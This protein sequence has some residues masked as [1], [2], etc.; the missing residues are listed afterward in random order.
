MPHTG[1]GKRFETPRA[2][3]AALRSP[4]RDPPSTFRS[5]PLATDAR[6]P[7][8]AR[9]LNPPAPN[10]PPARWRWLLPV[11]LLVLLVHFSPLGRSLDY[12][13]FDF[14]SRRPLIQPE[15]P[16]RSALV[17]I[18]DKTMDAL[19][20]TGERWPFRRGTFAA[21]LAA[22][23]R[24][25]AERILVDLTFL[26]HSDSAE[27]D[28]ILAVVAASSPRIVLAANGA[29]GPA[30]WDEE[31]RRENAAWFKKPRT[32]AVDYQVDPDGVPRRYHVRHSLAAAAFD[33]PAMGNG[34]LL[35]WHG[36]LA[37][38]QR[39]GV[40][41][42]PAGPFI[43]AGRGI[44]DRMV[45]AAPDLTPADLARAFHAEPTI[46][47]EAA[48]AVRGRVV[49]VGANA[50][51]TFDVKPLP[52]G[53][54]EPGVL[55]HWTA[56]SNLAGDGFIRPHPGGSFATSIL[57]LVTLLGG[58]HRSGGLRRPI[59]AAAGLVAL[60]VFGS[61]AGLSFG[62][63]FPPVTVVATVSLAL[64]GIIAE[65]FWAE[66]AR[67]REIQ[68]MFGAY[69][70]P[71]VVARLVND[72]QS[73][74][75][76]GEKRDATVFFSDLAGFTDLS[77][78]LRDQPERMVE[79]VNA[80][81]EETSE[82]LHRHGAYVDKYIGDAVMAVFGA[83]QELH[84][85][86]LDACRAALDAQKALEAINAR[87]AADVGVKLAVR[88]GLNTGEMIVGNLGSSRKKNYTVMG[89]AVNLGS[90]LEGANKHFGTGI[91]MGPETARRVADHLA[92]RPLARLRVKGK[93]EAVEVFTLHGEP[94]ALA[95]DERE[96]LEHYRLGY[97]AFMER[98]FA[99]AAASLARAESLR[100]GDQTTLDLRRQAEQFC[101]TPPTPDWEPV[102]TLESK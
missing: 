65:R 91:L 4:N 36:G 99:D 76:R 40:P 27:Q 14:A 51:G 37:D 60:V 73:I 10:S 20:A 54:L 97:Y 102:T 18:N 79:V 55:I 31:F 33:P 39:R 57:A 72:P 58:V 47:G 82:C 12:S 56:W 30:F 28:L 25:G 67:K 19:G 8:D 93:Q 46:T 63:F 17:M 34:G 9:R 32:G 16:G 94:A 66:Q 52:I 49:F 88:I 95:A 81:L 44:I 78:Q 7:S 68:T 71:S 101:R 13:F 41:V 15:L 70:D 2:T 61:Y 3:P 85:H 84:N 29:Q 21:L 77:E 26:D 89:D 62:W 83:P 59:G 64:I 80:Y 1:G 96:F 53:G 48:E 75:L 43:H 38:L 35:R 100:R 24:A 87:Y 50:P 23:D 42:L 98:R 90:R 69:V 22:I 11:A 5:T 45:A 92:I 74:P 86:A 6:V